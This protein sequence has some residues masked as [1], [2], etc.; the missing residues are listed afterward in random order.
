MK[1]T[2]REKKLQ[3]GRRALYL[4]YYPAVVI[5]NKQTR[6]E[7]LKLYIFE[8]PKTETEKEHNR[9]TKLLGENIRSQRQLELQAGV[10]GFALMRNKQKDFIEYFD[11]VVESKKNLSRSTYIIW[12]ATANHLRIF[13]SEKCRFG[14]VTENFC[15]N[16]KEYLLNHKE[17]AT[18]STATYWIKFNC[19]VRQAFENGLLPDNPAKRIKPI[20]IVE[21]Q[22]EFLTFEELQA[23]A[24]TPFQ[25]EDCRRAAL[26]SAFTGLRI[27]DIRKLI[28]GEVQHSKAQGFYIR[29]KQKKTKGAETLPIS[30]EAFELLGG[31]G[32]SSEKVFSNLMGWHTERLTEWAT[33]AGIDKKLTFHCFRHTF[34]TLQLTLGTDL[35]TV[36]KMLGHKDI[37]TTQI[38]AKIIDA[39]KREA[40]NKISL[41]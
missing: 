10:Y 9:E 17:L 28:W 32:P 35:Y 7:H 26:F 25:Y 27:S 22:R 3:H 40:A 29:F 8:K 41:K 36:S 12:R 33:A 1:V 11:Q 23:L 14:D 39:K 34:A 21:S 6:R 13:A 15:N 31:R 2:L 5:D 19:A 24:K 16:F 18:N 37:S 30:D 4:D 38:Y 20:R